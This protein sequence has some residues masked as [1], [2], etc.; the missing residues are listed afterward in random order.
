MA[1]LMT[2]C[3]CDIG[4]N[5]FNSSNRSSITVLGITVK[6][7]RSPNWI[8]MTVGFMCF[9]HH[10]VVYPFVRIQTIHAPTCTGDINI[11]S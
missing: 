2:N 10:E 6:H 7:F 5:Y 4:L 9:L 8:G 1:V 11:G 3:K